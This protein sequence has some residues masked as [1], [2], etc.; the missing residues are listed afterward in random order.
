LVDCVVCVKQTVDVNQLRPNPETL[1]PEYSKAPAKISDF[2]LNALEEALR[3][4][5]RHG[6]KVYVVCVGSNVQQLLIREALAMGADEAY[7]VSDPALSSA[8]G[9]AT[10]GVLASL[11]KSKIPSWDLIL[12][13]EAS[14]DEGAYQTG[15]R[16][17]EIL[18]IPHVSYVTKL[19]LEEGYVKAWK[20]MGG[21]VHVVRAKTPVLVTVGLEINTP[22]LP[23]LLMIRAAGKKPLNELKLQDIGVTSLEN[24][25]E[26]R[27][28]KAVKVERKK[29][30]IEGEP[31]E[32]AQKL[33]EIL[34]QEGLVKK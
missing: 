10:A 25:V 7:V 6:G 29:Q 34:L 28:V 9:L 18:N 21:S 31:E 4:R 32:V 8:D 27:R 15:P 13:G 23:S 24:A 2:D 33:V 14:V 19:E 5:E 3:I 12:C 30:V 1:E 22:R 16:L 26:T 11:I 17:A 20:G